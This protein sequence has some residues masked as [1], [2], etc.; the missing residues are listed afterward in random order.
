MIIDF[1]ALN[2]YNYIHWPRDLNKKQN[3]NL[4]SFF[5]LMLNLSFQ[6][7]QALPYNSVLNHLVYEQ[8]TSSLLYQYFHIEL[9]TYIQKH[10]VIINCL[11]QIR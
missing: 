6:C 9:T 3:K 8:A 11:F 7:K 2:T 4:V 5:A 10:V 1:L